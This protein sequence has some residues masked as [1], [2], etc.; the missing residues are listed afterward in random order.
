[1]KTVFFVMAALAV[2]SAKC[3]IAEEDTGDISAICVNDTT[4]VVTLE[5]ASGDS[6]TTAQIN[7][8]MDTMWI[9]ICGALV[10]FM[11]AGFGILEAGCISEKNVVNIMFKNVMDASVAAICYWLLGYGFAY[12]NGD[13]GPFIGTANFALSEEDGTSFHSFFFQWAF[14]ATAA[15]IVAG[16]VAERCKLEAYFVYSIVLTVFIYPVVSHWI[17][18]TEGW[19]SAFNPEPLF[20]GYGMID[21]AGCAVV[22]MVGGFAGL[23]AAKVIGPRTGRFEGTTTYEAHNQLYC[24]MGVLF[25]WFGW[26]GFNCGSTLGVSGGVSAIAGRVATTTTIA[27]GSGACT[28]SLLGRVMYGR[29][30]LL[31]CLNG[32]LAG[33]VSITS[34][35]FCVEPWAACVIGIIGVLVYKLASMLLVKLRIDDPLDA[36]PVHGF[37]GFWGALCPGIFSNDAL[38]KTVMGYDEEGT[39]VATGLQFL[40]QLVGCLAVVAWTVATSFVLFYTIKMTIGFRV[41][42]ATEEAGLDSSEHGAK[43][44]YHAEKVN[45]TEVELE[46]KA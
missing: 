30:D 4:G 8:D 6:A 38:L 11:Q 14:A 35:C 31:L 15:T 5:A 10:F 3:F 29:Y 44:Y 28:A 27:A 34:S 16:S 9:I 12:G 21:F 13:D 18:D 23:V 17:W 43:A 1:M 24:A 33:L 2:A 37:C 42:A 40:T 7:S 46:A 25:L 20:G 41:D 22:H 26:Y 19:L 45:P 39:N 32:I 36:A